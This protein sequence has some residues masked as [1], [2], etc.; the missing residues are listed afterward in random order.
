[1]V[2]YR[3]RKN[4]SMKLSAAVPFQ[5]PCPRAEYIGLKHPHMQ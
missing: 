3:F 5:V 1:M 4:R 2:S